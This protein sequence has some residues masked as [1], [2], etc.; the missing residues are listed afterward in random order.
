MATIWMP[1]AAPTSA[2][3]EDDEFHDSSL[4]ALW[5]EVDHGGTLTA[6][7]DE[8]G[9]KL[10]MTTHTTHGFA[11]IY[12]AIPS[13]DFTIWTKASVNCIRGT[14]GV[15]FT[16]ID[17][18]CAGLALWE[19]GTSATGDVTFFCIEWNLD[20]NVSNFRAWIT[21]YDATAYDAAATTTQV[22]EAGQ[23]VWPSHAYLRIRRTGT[24]YAFDFSGDGVAWQRLHSG[25]LAFTPTH[26]GPAVENR[27]R[28][29]G[30]DM[31]GRF[32][33]F[34]YVASDV[35]IA[36]TVGGRSVSVTPL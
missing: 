34:R 26:F 13:G 11:G 36:G 28:M 12:K 1:D 2:G 8:L 20:S 15:P 22:G 7:E 17:H 14:T 21:V 6:S 4:S 33:F 3:S 18:A 23:D 31:A 24:T 9:L 19:D 25:T 32:A 16:V 35:G 29:A 27:Y 5:A 30:A 10:L